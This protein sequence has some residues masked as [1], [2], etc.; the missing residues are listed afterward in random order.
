MVSRWMLI[1][2]RVGV[3]V[4]HLAESRFVSHITNQ[5][6]QQEVKSSLL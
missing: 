4:A 3:F 5:L 1:T 2:Y 6:V